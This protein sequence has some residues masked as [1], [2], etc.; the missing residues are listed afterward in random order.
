MKKIVD[1]GS[2]VSFLQHSPWTG[3]VQS[4]TSRCAEGLDRLGCS[5]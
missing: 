4:R 3:A 5:W 2:A 1:I